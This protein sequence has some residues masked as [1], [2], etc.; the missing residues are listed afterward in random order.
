MRALFL[1]PDIVFELNQS[2][3]QSIALHLF[4]RNATSPLHGETHTALA[5]YILHETRLCNKWTDSDVV[6]RWKLGSS[7]VLC[8]GQCLI[9]YRSFGTNYRS[10]LQGPASWDSFRNYDKWIL[11]VH[12]LAQLGFLG[13]RREYTQ[14]PGGVPTTAALNRQNEF[15]ENHSFFLFPFISKWKIFER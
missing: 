11:F 14:Q 1:A 5:K 3:N 9:P 12:S 7:R 8:S 6:S 2:I 10:H 13:G 15:L 4:C